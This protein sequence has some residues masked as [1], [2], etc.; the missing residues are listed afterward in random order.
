MV[1]ALSHN[2]KKIHRA[3]ILH[4]NKEKNNFYLCFFVDLGHKEYVNSNNIFEILDEV[5][6]V[7]SIF[8]IYKFKT[9]KDFVPSSMYIFFLDTLFSTQSKI[10]E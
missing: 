1:A 4:K 3:V 2:Y 7:S 8:C 10:E 9:R 6:N 5:K